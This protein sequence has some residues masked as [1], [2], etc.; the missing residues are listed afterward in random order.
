MLGHTPYTLMV[1][2][3]IDIS[4]R[5]GRMLTHSGTVYSAEIFPNRN[6][7]DL[8]VPSLTIKPYSNTQTQTYF[9]TVTQLPHFLITGKH[10]G[11]ASPGSPISTGPV[12][13]GPVDP[14]KVGDHK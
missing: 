13:P 3:S 6:C 1:E 4:T 2:K 14:T 7:R 8:T 12:D 9:I 5:K 11:M 10:T